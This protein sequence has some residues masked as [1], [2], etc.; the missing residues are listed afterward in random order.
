MGKDFNN[1]IKSFDKTLNKAPKFDLYKLQNRIDNLNKAT[2]KLSEV[3]MIM[4]NFIEE[5]SNNLINVFSR[6]SKYFNEVIKKLDFSGIS[7]AV[8]LRYIG[9][10]PCL[11]LTKEEK[12]EIVNILQEINEENVERAK[13]IIFKHYNNR[14]IDKI[15]NEWLY[16]EYINDSRFE[17][18]EQALNCYIN[19]QYAACVSLITCQYGG[20]IYETEKYFSS[21]PNL[22]NEIEKYKEEQRKKIKEWKSSPKKHRIEKILNTSEKF[23]AERIYEINM[24]YTTALFS[25]YIK[26]YVYCDS[27]EAKDNIPNRNGVCHGSLINYNTQE[28][29]LKSILIVDSLIRLYMFIDIEENLND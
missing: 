15:Y 19:K 8:K 12:I 27:K 11:D 29:A 17:L 26:K 16:N 23:K 10:L 20:I 1:A 24:H 14:I 25:E 3:G 4:G 6:F 2:L 5:S 22:N 7:C 18:L 28:H 9:W 13:D 21:I